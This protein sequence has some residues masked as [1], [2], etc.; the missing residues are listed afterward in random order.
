[1]SPSFLCVHALVYKV[2][3]RWFSIHCDFNFYHVCTEHCFNLVI[4]SGF[5]QHP[6][7]MNSNACPQPPSCSPECALY[8]VGQALTHILVV[9]L[10]LE[11]SYE[12]QPAAPYLGLRVKFKNW[13]GRWVPQMQL[14]D[15]KLEGS[16]GKKWDSRKSG[17]TPPGRGSWMAW[18]RDGT[19][20]VACPCFGTE[21][22]VSALNWATSQQSP[23]RDRRPRGQ[24]PKSSCIIPNH[25]VTRKV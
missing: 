10:C 12:G 20:H 17:L 16:G 22:P 6:Q 25:P 18:C 24:V 7:T 4:F 3:C 14:H 5:L 1:M 21:I 15:T 2:G 13:C 9:G 8:A 11:G 23:A 19:K